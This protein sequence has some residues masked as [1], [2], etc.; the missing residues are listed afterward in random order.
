MKYI[1]L[2]IVLVF[3]TNTGHSQDMLYK[4]DGSAI[5]CKVKGITI[6]V[7]KYKRTDIKNSPVFEVKKDEVYK[8]RF[9]K[10]KKATTDILDPVFNKQNGDTIPYSLVYIVYHSNQSNKNLQLGVD[11]FYNLTIKNHSRLVMKFIYEE[12][13]NIHVE[14]TFSDGPSIKF[15]TVHGQNYAICVRE[16]DEGKGNSKDKFSMTLYKDPKEVT[17]FIKNEYNGFSPDKDHYYYWNE[18]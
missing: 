5:S 15:V 11:P 17:D 7:I 2:L 3:L 10:G 18:K 13:R 1:T 6:D 12:E 14:K 8:I 9:K 16:K 4:K